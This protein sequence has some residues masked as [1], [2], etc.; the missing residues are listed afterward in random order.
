[1]IVETMWQRN[2]LPGAAKGRTRL[3]ADW[4]RCAPRRR[5][6]PLYD[7]VMIIFAFRT[8]GG[9]AGRRHEPGICT[10]PEIASQFPTR[11]AR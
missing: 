8:C 5:L 2:V 9:A 7:D 4:A 3:L 11:E 10:L 1:M 6:L